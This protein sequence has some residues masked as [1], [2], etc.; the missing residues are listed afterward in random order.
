MT[1]KR[2]FKPAA[3]YPADPRAVFIL[4]LSVFSGATALA[5]EAAPESLESLLPHW[6]VIVWGVLL[7]AGSSLTLLGMARQTDWGIIAEQ[8]GSV[9]VGATTVYY[10]IIA[11][12]QVGP[13]V[14]QNVGIIMAWGLACFVRWAQLQALVNQVATQTAE[15]R[16]E[17]AVQE[18]LAAD[19]RG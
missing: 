5:L 8:V 14:L 13:N 1:L 18:R 10:S 17:A 4:A 15:H 6:A 16:I 11:L 2:V 19:E 7:M 9:M 3:R 12:W